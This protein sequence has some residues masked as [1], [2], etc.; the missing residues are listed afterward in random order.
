[1]SFSEGNITKPYVLLTRIELIKTKSGKIYCERL[2]AKD[3]LLHLGYIKDFQI[4]CPI[5]YRE[6]IDG[7]I[8]ISNYKISRIFELKKD[9]GFFSIIRNI[10]PNFLVVVKACENASIVHSGGAGWAFPLSFYLLFI[11]DFFSFKWVILIES[12][13]WMLSKSERLTFRRY[14]VHH[15]YSW[16]LTLCVK[17]A[18][19]RIF[20]QTFYRNYFLHN[21]RHKTLIAPASWVDKSSVISVEKVK[22]RYKKKVEKTIEIIFPARLEEN[23]GVRVLFS[24]IEALSAMNVEVN[25]TLMG[26][27]ALRDECEKFALG[28]FG[29]VK[30]AF[31][32]PVIYGDE[33]FNVLCQFDAVL[34]PNIKEEQP[35]IIFDAFSQGVPVIASDT[36]GICDITSNRVNALHCKQGDPK[37]LASAVSYAVM[38]SEILVELG[39]NGLA[40][41]KSKTHLQM[42]I[43]RYR[44]LKKVFGL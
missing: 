41:A 12:S 5:I 40:Y 27:G 43:D 2:W 30:V 15:S 36:W 31:K 33:F 32:E 39:L 35:R 14:F 7:L 9:F 23:K 37:S 13:F 42:H 10:I 24:A 16:L 20:T 29:P 11:K 25:I 26:D 28:D 19:A 8:D 1:L 6:N 34:V 38:N 21:N 44:F 18:D 17:K 22:E 4:C 3:L